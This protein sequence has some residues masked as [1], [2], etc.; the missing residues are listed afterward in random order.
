VPGSSYSGGFENFPRF[1]E[2]W[3]GINC[4]INGS[5]VNFWNSQFATGTWGASGVYSA[6]NRLWGYDPM[7]NTVANLPPFTPMAVTAVDVVCW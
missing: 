5:F 2:N 1:H 4:T 7:F 3:G 6:P